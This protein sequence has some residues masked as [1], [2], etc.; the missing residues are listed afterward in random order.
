VRVKTIFLYFIMIVINSV[1]FGEDRGCT[2]KE[3]YPDGLTCTGVATTSMPQEISENEP[4]AIHRNST[5]VLID[6]LKLSDY[7]EAGQGYNIYYDD[8]TESLKQY[9]LYEEYPLTVESE[10]AIAR[11]PAWLRNNL[12]TVLS[13]VSELHQPEWASAINTANDPYIDEIAFSI[14]HLSPQY[15]SANVAG[16][17]YGSA[18]LL[19]ENAEL[20]Y[21]NDQYLDYV[22]VIDYG[23]STTDENYYSTTKYRKV[24]ARGD[25]I[26][27]EVPK[28]IYYWYIVDPK[29]TDEIPAFIDPDIIEDNITHNNNIADPPEGVFWRDYLF[30]QADAGYPVL[31]DTLEGC[32]I[33]W[34]GTQNVNASMTHAAAVITRWINATM[35]FT[36]NYERPH[37][38]VR[39][40]K[41][42][43]G[44]CGE[45]ADFTAAAARAAL[46]PCTSILAIS[47]DHTWNEFWD[48][49]WIHWEPVNNSLNNPLV[50]ENGWGKVFG[51]VFEIRSDGWLT[52]VTDRYSEGAATI[53]IY[54][55]DSQG[56]PIDGAE[57]LLGVGSGTSILVDNYGLTDNEGKYTFVVGEGKH[58]YARVDTDI[59]SNPIEPGST[60]SLID[61][62]IDDEDYYFNFDISGTM[63]SLNY[64]TTD[65]P[66]DLNDDYRLD[67]SFTV[68]SEIVTGVSLF[69]DLDNV[70]LYKQEDTGNIDHVMIAGYD[71]IWYLLNEPFN[72]FNIFPDATQGEIAFYIPVGSDWYSCL[73]NMLHLNNYQYVDGMARLFHY[74]VSVDEPSSNGSKDL[75]LINN[76]NPFTQST[77]IS[78]SSYSNHHEM[79]HLTIFNIKGQKIRSI[80]LAH[81]DD[82]YSAIWDGT[83]QNGNKVQQGVYFYMIDIDGETYVNKMIH[84]H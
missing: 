8:D 81:A 77:T 60:I 78:L 31:K 50:Y 11:A 1:I 22:E 66:E 49:E 52:S 83:D 28:E 54:A 30:N 79:S 74:N 69:D 36:S 51:S 2:H 25:T 43:I 67:V 16:D 14:A 33:V 57:V 71:L 38:P 35:S 10:Q 27:V 59:G 75:I 5:W 26:E 58:F 61:N 63:P 47:G 41:K 6:S 18:Q 80:E 29:I 17:L 37:Q 46:I 70:E 65:V 45:Y 72:A 44:R 73:S 53:T 55:L 84:M 32:T 48:E 7:V 13:H 4:P 68:P 62:T 21:L 23:T 56:N 76:P 20:I 39:I 3:L 42:H 12:R 34:D 9:P 24:D 40:Y 15:L 82:K 64:V 19:Q